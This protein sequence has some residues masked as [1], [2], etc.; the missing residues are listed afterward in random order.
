MKQFLLLVLT[1]SL[2]LPGFALMET[3]LSQTAAPTPPFPEELPEGLE[4]V[5]NEEQNQWFIVV[6]EDS[7]KI[8]ELDIPGVSGPPSLLDI[9][10][11]DTPAEDAWALIHFA[12]SSAVMAKTMYPVGLAVFQS[13]LYETLDAQ[14]FQWEAEL[15]VDSSR[16]SLPLA[17]SLGPE[18]VFI[19]R[20]HLGGVVTLQIEGRPNTLGMTLSEALTPGF[21]EGSREITITHEGQAYT[22]TWAD[23]EA[24]M[25]DCVVY[26]IR[27]IIHSPFEEMLTQDAIIVVQ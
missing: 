12:A 13:G 19:S 9:P 21:V 22:T 5:F 16:F 2:M 17:E 20:F 7:V 11:M 6:S 3:G 8:V 10:R 27:L 23:Y 14:R 1:I 4:W 18:K 25:A 26:G 24:A 15:R